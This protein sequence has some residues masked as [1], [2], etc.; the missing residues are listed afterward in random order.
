MKPA[1]K[2]KEAYCGGVCGGERRVPRFLMIDQR[3]AP[4][5]QTKTI[6]LRANLSQGQR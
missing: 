3:T 5:S 1:N 2:A 6:A 4:Y